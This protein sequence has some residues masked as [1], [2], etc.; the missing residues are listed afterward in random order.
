MMS[1]MTRKKCQWVGRRGVFRS[2]QVSYSNMFSAS[3]SVQH[4]GVS[5]NGDTTSTKCLREWLLYLCDGFITYA[6]SCVF[7]AATSSITLKN[8]F[9]NL[10]AQYVLSSFCG[11]VSFSHCLKPCSRCRP[12]DK[13]SYGD[14]ITTAIVLACATYSEGVKNLAAGCNPMDLCRG[15]QATTDSFFKF[16]CSHTKTITTTAEIAQVA[17]ISANGDVYVT[18]LIAPAIK[19]VRKEGV[20]AVKEGRAIG[21]E[22]EITESMCF[23]YG[24]ISLHFVDNAKAQWVEFEKPVIFLSGKK[25]S[26][27]QDIFRRRC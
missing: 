14:G 7:K 8:K 13:Q 20:I 26:L 16:F 19:K 23:D 1:L 17:T 18:N 15:S 12:K 9:T 10:G 11:R 22:I 4:T 21:D 25:I 2:Q 5:W 27:L 3:S 6:A 24:F